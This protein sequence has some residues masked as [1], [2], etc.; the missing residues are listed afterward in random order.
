MVCLTRFST[1]PWIKQC[2]Y[3]QTY[4][5]HTHTRGM[6]IPTFCAIM[7]C[8]HGE[9]G[10][11]H[12]SVI[13]LWGRGGPIRETDCSLTVTLPALVPTALPPTETQTHPPAEGPICTGPYCHG[14]QNRL[15]CISPY[16]SIFFSFPLTSIWKIK[17]M[18]FFFFFFFVRKCKFPSKF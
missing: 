18:S 17:V 8:C 12:N 9:G 10:L 5:T 4:S 1:I 14:N 13:V 7:W 2:Y 15:Q 6:E 16:I 3:E 11:R